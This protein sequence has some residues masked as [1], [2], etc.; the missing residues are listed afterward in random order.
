MNQS[1]TPPSV[2]SCKTMSTNQKYALNSTKYTIQ[3]IKLI[4]NYY[5]L[6]FTP[7]LKSDLQETAWC[8]PDM[9]SARLC[10]CLKKTRYPAVWSLDFQHFF[11]STQKAKCWVMILFIAS[12]ILNCSLYLIPYQQR[13]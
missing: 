2:L 6:L 11:S 4:R 10:H 12:F 8:E 3:K 13:H 1:K 5:H 9:S 7:E